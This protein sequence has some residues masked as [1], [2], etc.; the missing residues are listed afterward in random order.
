MLR[1]PLLGYYED[2]SARLTE[3]PLPVRPGLG[4]LRP[5]VFQIP[6]EP[7][8]ITIGDNSIRAHIH[9]KI[10]RARFQALLHP[11]AMISPSCHVGNG[12][13]IYHGS[14]VQAGTRIGKHAIIN[15][16]ANIDHD[17]LIGDFAHV[18]PGAT[19]CGGIRVGIGSFIGAGAIV[20]PGIQIGA[21]AIVGAGA[22]VTRDVPYGA[23]VVGTP[24]RVIAWNQQ[25]GA[26]TN[27]KKRNP[28][29]HGHPP[30]ST[31]ETTH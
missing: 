9:S 20:L 11:S 2:N 21:W 17:N 3:E 18:S 31:N 10:P 25:A 8:V 1:L 22:V 26:V 28:P 14:I 23:T 27:A 5:G 30:H 7:I 13:V 6:A 19:L 29:N 15:T 12:T 16:S 4:L 24:A